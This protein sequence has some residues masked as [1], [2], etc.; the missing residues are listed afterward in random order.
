MFAEAAPQ[1]KHADLPAA[2]R[3]GCLS[4]EFVSLCDSVAP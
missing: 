3:L 1:R 4:R 2:S